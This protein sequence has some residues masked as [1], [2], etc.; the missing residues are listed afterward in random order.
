M[1]IEGVHEGNGLLAPS[2]HVTG[3]VLHLSGWKD[4]PT[5]LPIFL[6]F[7]NLAEASR[8]LKTKF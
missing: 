5:H 4:I 1:S 7:Q 3:S 2:V 8:G 6:G